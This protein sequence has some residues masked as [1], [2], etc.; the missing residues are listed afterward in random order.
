MSETHINITGSSQLPTADIDD[1][2]GDQRPKQRSFLE[3]FVDSFFQEKNIKWMLVVGAAIVFGSSLML[4]TKA[5][6]SWSNVLKYMT[7]LGYTGVIFAAAEV[8]RKRLG[9]TATYKV[10]HVLTLLLLP[11]C[12]LALRWLTAESSTQI[13]DVVE[14]CGLL[15]PATAFLWFTS[16]RILDHL[17]RGRSCGRGRV[18]KID[19][20]RRP[21]SLRAQQL[22][23]SNRNTAHRLGL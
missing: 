15:L 20:D 18:H 21:R 14:F 13:W 6:P 3:S 4:V 7:I 17:L 11:V 16:S 22:G 12:F 19:S 10:L 9:L 5:W 23:K 8:S 1:R 2:T